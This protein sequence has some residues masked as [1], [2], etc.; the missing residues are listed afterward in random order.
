MVDARR[1]GFPESKRTFYSSLEEAS[2]V[3]E[4]LEIELRNHGAAGFGEQS[5]LER[6]D[7]IQA[8]RILARFPEATLAE[9]AECLAQAL[10]AKAKAAAGPLVKDALESFLETKRTDYKTGVLRKLSLYDLESKTRHL[11]VELG[12]Q[13]LPRVDIATMEEFLGRLNLSPRAR[14]NVRS[15][16]SQFFNYCLRRKLI[17]ENPAAGLGKK[18]EAHDVEILSVEAAENLLRTAERSPY[19]ANVMP[20]LCVSLFAGLRPGEAQQLK[21]EQ[22]HFETKQIEVL[23]HTT[24]TKQTRYVEVSELLIEWLLPYRKARGPIV[25]KHF[26]N[27]WRAV[28]QNAGYDQGSNRWVADILRHS[29]ASYWLPIHQHRGQLAEEMGNSI[30]MIKRHYRRA[31]PRG[32]AEAFWQIRPTLE[33]GKVLPFQATG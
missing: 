23:R 3:A 8:R 18:I 32:Q 28:R 25:G 27:E 19:A 29:F 16:C 4:R 21:W 9:A 14:E 24:K 13:P 20:Y 22:I 1:V 17:T 33:L 31:I 30:Q 10:E 15:K 26:T 5:A 7:A 12:D 11:L 6:R 2:A